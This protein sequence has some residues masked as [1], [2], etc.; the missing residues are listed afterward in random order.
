M[1]ATT[2]YVGT[3]MAR[4]DL[5]HTNIRPG[6]V[7]EGK[8]TLAAPELHAAS[9]NGRPA[10]AVATAAICYCFMPRQYLSIRRHASRAM[11]SSRNF[12]RIALRT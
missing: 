7:C 8:V 9:N 12:R 2:V 10:A 4:P 5:G 11:F 6:L 3:A 1:N